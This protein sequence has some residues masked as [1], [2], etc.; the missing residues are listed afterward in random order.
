MIPI[1]ELLFVNHNIV[2][3]LI[4]NRC[5]AQRQGPMES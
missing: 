2:N 4:L 5:W 1:I 3:S